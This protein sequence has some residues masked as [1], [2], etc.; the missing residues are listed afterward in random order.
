MQGKTIAEAA[1]CLG[2]AP[3][4]FVR[5]LNGEWRPSK[6]ICRKMGL[7]VVYAVTGTVAAGICLPN[8][9]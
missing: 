1:E 6:E 7:K 3:K 4:Q 8:R 2:M 5:L 9:Y